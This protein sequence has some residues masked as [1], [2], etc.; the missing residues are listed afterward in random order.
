MAS[1]ETGGRFIILA[2]ECIVSMM[3]VDELASVPSR[4][5][6]MAFFMALTLLVRLFHL[7]RVPLLGQD[8]WLMCPIEM[9]TQVHS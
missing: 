3:Q 9:C 2:I 7:L 8:L 4:S 5:K 1:S 6:T